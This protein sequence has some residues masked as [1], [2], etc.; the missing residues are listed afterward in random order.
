MTPPGLSC[1]PEIRG[2][3][4]DLGHVGHVGEQVVVDVDLEQPSINVLLPCW[5]KLFGTLRDGYF[6]ARRRRS[7]IKRLSVRNSQSEQVRGRSG[8]NLGRFGPNLGRSGPRPLK[9]PKVPP[10][11]SGAPE[12]PAAW[13]SNKSSAACARSSAP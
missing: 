4:D 9:A 11:L 8:P 2:A 10:E 1:P 12:V 6:Q 5:V 3:V 13:D 7:I